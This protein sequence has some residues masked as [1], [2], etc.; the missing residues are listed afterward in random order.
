MYMDISSVWALNKKEEVKTKVTEMRILKRM[1]GTTRSDRIGN[2]CMREKLGMTDMT[3]K[4][5]DNRFR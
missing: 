3:R 5:G 4:M 1:H 2:A